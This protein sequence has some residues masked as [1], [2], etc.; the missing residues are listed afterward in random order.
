MTAGPRWPG[1]G[2]YRYQ[3]VRLCSS[4]GGTWTVPSAFLPT[5]ITGASTPMTGMRMLTGTERASGFARGS[6]VSRGAVVV[7]EA[8]V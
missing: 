4:S 2:P 8:G 3:P 6:R 7:T 5:S 1:V